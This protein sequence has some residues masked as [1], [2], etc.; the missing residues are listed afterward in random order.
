MELTELKKALAAEAQAAGICSDWYNFILSAQDKGRLLALYFKGF[1]FVEENDFP[2]EPLRREFDDIRR[3][4]N[5][6]EK[7]PFA[8]RNPRRL[9]AYMGALGTVALECFAVTQVWARPGSEVKVTA[10]D[11]AFVTVDLAEGAKVDVKAEGQARVIVFHHG[12][13]LTQQSEGHAIIKI[14]NK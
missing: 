5:I 8:A 13:T 4:Y 7:E 1:D 14:K 9:V 3:A 10:K 2:S 6:Y 11:N 12:G